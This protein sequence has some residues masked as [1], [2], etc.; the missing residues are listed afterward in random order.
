MLT[1]CTLC[2]L[3]AGEDYIQRRS[4]LTISKCQNESCVSVTII[5][6]QSVEPLREIFSVA[7]E[8]VQEDS[9]I[10]IDTTPSIIMIMD[11]D[12][13]YIL[14]IYSNKYK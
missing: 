1:L 3:V 4:P 7:L 6:D 13:A 14:Y 2:V 10:T 8:A 12:G 11:D 9:R 5:N